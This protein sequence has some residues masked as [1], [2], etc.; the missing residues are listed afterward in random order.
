MLDTNTVSYIVK[1]KSPAA[2]KRLANLGPDE[3]ACISAVT[4]F[5]LEYGL[6]KNPNAQSLREGLRW[7]LARL[8]TLPL[9]SAQARTY[10][11]ARARQEAAGQPLESLDM[12]IAAHALSAGAVLVTHDRVF[13]SVDGLPIQ[14]WATDL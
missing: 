13:R 7:F 2:R 5:E 11:Q 3:I 10:G 8:R 1:G 14:D 12:L 4:Q 6:A 9:D